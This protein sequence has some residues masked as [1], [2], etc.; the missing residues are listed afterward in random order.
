MKLDFKTYLARIILIIVCF[1]IVCLCYMRMNQSYDELARY[2]YVNDENRDI[3]LQNLDND[4]I[5][6]MINQQIE[7]DQFMDFI[8]LD[9]F[10][11][12]NTL[13]YS[14]AKKTQNEDNQVIVNFVNRYRS[15]FSLKTLPNLLTYYSYHDLITFYE[16]EWVLN[17]NLSLESDL[18]NPFVILS[19]S[20]TIYKFKPE[21]VSYKN[22]QIKQEVVDD[23]Q[24]MCD[25]YKKVIGQELSL[26][27]GYVDYETL[28]NFYT[29]FKEQYPDQVDSFISCAGQNELQLGYSIV[30]EGMSEWL[31]AY[32]N[33]ENEDISVE[34]ANK[35]TLEWLQ[36]NAYRYGFVIRYPQEKESQTGKEYNPYLLRYVGR[37][38]AKKMYKSNLCMEEMEFSNSL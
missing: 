31:E 11:M 8:E 3:I 33:N 14:A 37:K 29:A 28:V 10:E 16:T 35:E 30:I 1:C 38:N 6:Y 5:N 13:L 9:G 21:V 18:S 7:P 26:Y 4:D 24:A 32:L 2:P 36:D 20:K 27:K 12:H 15:H 23:L 25:D 34:F 22:I 19:D 17:E